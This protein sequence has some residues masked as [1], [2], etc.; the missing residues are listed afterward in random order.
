[1]VPWSRRRRAR[2]RPQAASRGTRAGSRPAVET[3]LHVRIWYLKHEEVTGNMRRAPMPTLSRSST[4]S[5]RCVT[6]RDAEPMRPTVRKTYLVHVHARDT[7]ARGGEGSTRG[8]RAETMRRDGALRVA[9]RGVAS[10]G[11]KPKNGSE[12]GRRRRATRRARGHDRFDTIDCND[13]GAP[14]R[15]GRRNTHHR[16]ARRR[17]WTKKHTPPRRA[18]TSPMRA[19]TGRGSRRR[20]AGSRSGRSRRT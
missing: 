20:G 10:G 15:D 11:G 12:R 5:T 3:T 14:P 6:S 7:S 19:L 9:R 8:C 1:M 13:R 17:R 2:A 18:T 16:D 4:Y